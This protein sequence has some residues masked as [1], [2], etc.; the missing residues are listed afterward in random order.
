MVTKKK[1][2]KNS[3]WMQ[4]AFANSRGQFKAKAKRA[5][6]STSAYATEVLKKKSKAS[7]KTKKQAVLAR[8]GIKY[9]RKK[10]KK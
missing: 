9:A 1:K 6:K 7:K 5:G 3:H 2:K 8:T 10:A 4:K